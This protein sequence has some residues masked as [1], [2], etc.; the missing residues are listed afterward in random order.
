MPWFG[1]LAGWQADGAGGRHKTYGTDVRI[2][3]I[4]G[5]GRVSIGQ[6]G[7]E[8]DDDVQGQPPPSRRVVV[9]IVREVTADAGATRVQCEDTLLELRTTALSQNRFHGGKARLPWS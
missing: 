4:G 3:G 9:A 8:G 5:P 2:G 1:Q 6:H 7:I